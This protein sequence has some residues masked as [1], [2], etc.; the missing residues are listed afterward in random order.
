PCLTE[1]EE[2]PGDGHQLLGLE[3]RTLLGAVD[4]GA[5]VLEPGEGQGD[6]ILE[7]AAPLGDQGEG[8]PDG[9]WITE[10]GS[11][12]AARLAQRRAARGGEGEERLGPAEVGEGL[13]RG[14]HEAAFNAKWGGGQAPWE[15]GP[16]VPPS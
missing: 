1:G 3:Q 5:D 10:E 11:L 9:C 16:P 15:A 12:E 2:N 4:E 6:L 8:L 7:E 13:Q 14:E